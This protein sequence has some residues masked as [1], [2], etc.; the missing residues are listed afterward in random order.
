MA[1]K[2]LKKMLKENSI[3]GVEVESAG[4]ATLPSYRIFGDLKKVLGEEELDVNGHTPT[5]ITKEMLNNADLILVMEMSHKQYIL[6]LIP[7]I[8]KKV[9]LLKEYVIGRKEGV[10]DPIG[11][12]YDVYKKTMKEIKE[13]IRILITKLKERK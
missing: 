2:L 9:F 1:E 3:N 7:G 13:L 8:K 11:M 10:S 12:P 5:Q 4:I 6:N